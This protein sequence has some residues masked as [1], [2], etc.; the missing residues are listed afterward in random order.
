MSSVEQLR[1]VDA[2]LADLRERETETRERIEALQAEL[3]DA[4]AE[5]RETGDVHSQID[6]LRAELEA[7]PAAISRVEAERVEASVAV[8]KERA[9]SKV[10][11]IRRA[12]AEI[13][14]ALAEA[15]D[16]LERVA[17]AAADRK[18][19]AYFPLEAGAIAWSGMAARVREHAATVE[20]HRVSEVQTS[21]DR[22]ISSLRAEYRRRT[23]A[24]TPGPDRIVRD[25][26]AAPIRAANAVLARSGAG[27]FAE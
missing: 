2:R 21:A 16:A 25:P 12:A 11:E 24:D 18:D 14:P 1:I 8:E 9:E 22:R 10:L 17:E 3:S 27:F 19:F 15:A 7:L 20:S 23:G 5:G 26:E 4:L 13:R 6:R